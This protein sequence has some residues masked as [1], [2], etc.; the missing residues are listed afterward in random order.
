MAPRAEIFRRDQGKIVDFQDYKNMLRYNDYLV[1]PYSHLN[2]GDAICSRFDLTTSEPQAFGCIDTKVTNQ[3]LHKYLIAEAVNGPTRSN[4]LPAFS[5]KPE[6]NQTAH[7]GL[8]TTFDFDFV[9]MDPKWD[10]EF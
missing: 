7:V 6:F 2:P 5:W 9:T 10:V 8:P 3:M 1:D 4:G